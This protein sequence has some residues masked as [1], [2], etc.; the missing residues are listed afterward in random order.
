M[1]VFFKSLYSFIK[2]PSG[3]GEIVKHKGL[4]TSYVTGQV[5]QVSSNLFN[6]NNNLID[7]T[8]VA[9][10]NGSDD[11]CLCRDKTLMKTERE[12]HLLKT[13]RTVSRHCTRIIKQHEDAR[14]QIQNEIRKIKKK[15]P[16]TALKP[17]AVLSVRDVA[18]RLGKGRLS[19]GGQSKAVKRTLKG[20]KPIGQEG[21]DFKKVSATKTHVKDQTAERVGDTIYTHVQTRTYFKAKDVM[22]LFRLDTL[23]VAPLVKGRSDVT[24][25]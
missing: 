4:K 16:L 17:T 21:I 6:L 9:V 12:T 10:T 13:L 11:L 15:I 19:S 14:A 25:S 7:K 5:T 23:S 8:S 20:I 1:N 22:H 18:E 24:V 2:T 3:R